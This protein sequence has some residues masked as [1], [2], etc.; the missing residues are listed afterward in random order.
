MLDVNLGSGTSFARAD[1]VLKRKIPFIFAT[2]YGD[3]ALIQPA[4]N[5][6]PVEQ[7]PYTG[8]TLP[9]ALTVALGNGSKT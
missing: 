1:E 9:A 4:F 6:T 3:R 5:D 2:R 8:A 7:K